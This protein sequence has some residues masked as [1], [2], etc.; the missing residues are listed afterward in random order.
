MERVPG[1]TKAGKSG[2]ACCGG[3]DIGRDSK[4]SKPTV[5]RKRERAQATYRDNLQNLTF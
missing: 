3:V 5:N 2:I 4:A 1:R